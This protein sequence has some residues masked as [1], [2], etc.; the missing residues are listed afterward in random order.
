MAT[1][2]QQSRLEDIIHDVRT[3]LAT[4]KGSL[5]TVLKHWHRLEESKRLEL[6]SRALLVTNQLEFATERAAAQIERNTRTGGPRRPELID[7]TIE[8][9]DDAPSAQVTL[10]MS[11]EALSGSAAS[12]QGSRRD[13]TVASRATLQ[14][15]EPLL[16]D[17]SF[18]LD[19]AG[20]LQIGEAPFAVVRIRR[21]DDL[22]VGSAL[23]ESDLHVSMARATL[24]AL[25]RVVTRPRRKTSAT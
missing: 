16:E 3:P 21:D 8:E 13:P 18:R 23:I 14:A 24:D 15:L 11:G 7:L 2:R 4:A 5:E 19:E 1:Q 6:V 9:P 25:N 10:T 17:A 12:K 20:V 22:L